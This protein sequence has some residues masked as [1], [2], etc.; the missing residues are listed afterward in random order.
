M[1]VFLGL[2]ERQRRKPKAR[3]SSLVLTESAAALPE[4]RRSPAAVGEE[5]PPPPRPGCGRRAHRP[6]GYVTR[7]PGA[8]R[9]RAGDRGR[10]PSSRPRP[11]ICSSAGSC[12]CRHLGWLPGFPPASIL[13]CFLPCHTGLAPSPGTTGGPGPLRRGASRET[14]SAWVAPGSRTSSRLDG[15]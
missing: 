2:C 5:R 3:E 14:V 4:R 12:F 15:S 6:P 8:G 1:S 9:A 7:R 10:S 13:K 11:L